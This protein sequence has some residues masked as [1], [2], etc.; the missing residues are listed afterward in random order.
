MF[1]VSFPINSDPILACY[2][3]F[4]VNRETLIPFSFFGLK[5]KT[6]L[7]VQNWEI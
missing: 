1:V 6:I 4:Y 5:T 7:R 2:A 3:I